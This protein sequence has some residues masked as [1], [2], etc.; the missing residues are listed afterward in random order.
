MG[1]AIKKTKIKWNEVMT[2]LYIRSI[3]GVKYLFRL[4]RHRCYADLKYFYPQSNSYS[5]SQLECISNMPRTKRATQKRKRNPPKSPPNP[6]RV[7]RTESPEKINFSSVLTD[8][9]C[10]AVNVV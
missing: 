2:M 4:L 1:S 3:F 7:K 5:Y 6:K 10:Y 9:V 8:D